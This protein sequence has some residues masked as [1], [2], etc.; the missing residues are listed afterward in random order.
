MSQ[1]LITGLP[2]HVWPTDKQVQ[3]TKPELSCGVFHAA[4]NCVA[5]WADQIAKGR[6][7]PNFVSSAG[8]RSNRLA[9]AREGPCPTCSHPVVCAE[10]E[11]DF[12]SQ[13]FENHQ[14]DCGF[15]QTPLDGIVDPFDNALLLTVRVSHPGRRRHPRTAFL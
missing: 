15:C 1:E 2:R 3:K 11:A 13:S 6:R 7:M 5:C 9:R 14:L 4:T 8:L 10:A 12:D